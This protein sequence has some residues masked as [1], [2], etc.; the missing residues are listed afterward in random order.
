MT[1]RMNGT[2]K[3]S[4][5]PLGRNPSLLPYKF[6]NINGGKN[7]RNT[8]WLNRC[9]SSS[10]RSPVRRTTKPMTSRMNSGMTALMQITKL[11]NMKVEI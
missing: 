1:Q 4:N 5:F 11:L 9:T 10:F 2:A 8:M 3:R 7:T 6:W